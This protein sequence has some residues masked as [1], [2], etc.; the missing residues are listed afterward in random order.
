[1]IRSRSISAA[2]L[3]LA[4]LL[5]AAPAGALSIRKARGAVVNQTLEY[6]NVPYLWGGQHPK[7][8]LDCS[9]F[10]QLVYRKAGLKVPRVSRDQFK[11]TRPVSPKRLLP[12]D[13]VF[14]AMKNPGTAKVDHV[15]IYMG[16]EIFIHASFTHGIHVERIT[17]PYFL[18]RLVGVRSYRG[19]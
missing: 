18:A 8:G 10:V 3:A 15:G 17:K 5:A 13:L 19:F 16:K 11:A 6:L 2:C 9:A 14:F 4:C 7:T 1:M 12:G